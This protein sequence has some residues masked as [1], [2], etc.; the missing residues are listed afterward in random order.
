MIA[1]RFVMGFLII[2]FLVLL[3]GFV[4][5]ALCW[6]SYD[7][8]VRGCNTWIPVTLFLG[9]PII[10]AFIAIILRA[11]I[12]F[13]AGITLLIPFIG[14]VLWLTTRPRRLHQ[15]NEESNHSSLS[16]LRRLGWLCVGAAIF[17]AATPFC[18][19]FLV[20]GAARNVFNWKATIN[21]STHRLDPKTFHFPNGKIVTLNDPKIDL[22]YTFEEVEFPAVDGKTLRGW[23]VPGKVVSS[24]AI[25]AVHGMGEDRRDFLGRMPLLHDA[26]YSVLLFD[27]RNHGASDGDGEGAT[28]AINESRDV[29]S[30]VR[31]MKRSRGFS[32]IVAI[33]I[34]QGAA[35]S[36]L[37]A[38]KDP[39]I[40]GV[41]ADSPFGN[42]SDLIGSAAKIYGLPHWLA[43]FT[44]HMAYWRL[45]ASSTGYPLEAVAH[46]S[47]RPLLLI[48]CTGD[49]IIPFQASQALFARAGRP[50]SLWLIPNSFHTGAFL[51]H[52]EEYKQHVTDFLH[53]FFRLDKA[54][55]GS[56]AF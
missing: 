55:S 36:I 2:G 33:G 40:D 45:N 24:I 38:G 10:G 37:A 49:A 30:A 25:V 16:W 1:D 52:Q 9:S 4:S 44:V 51:N 12:P 20:V 28:L 17:I 3:V 19:S 53:T 27:C 43:S 35:S 13:V 47:P 39:N 34:S 46:I 32:H 42:F 29:S 22:G 48:H 21:P 56:A 54:A 6:L 23:L 31:Y 7:A 26:G 15:P 41:I 50:K 5:R 8:R 18:I 11:R 14:V